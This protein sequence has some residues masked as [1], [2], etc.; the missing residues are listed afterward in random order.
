MIY[1][2]FDP[3]EVCCILWQ[4]WGV[5]QNI[6]SFIVDWSLP[7]LRFNRV[8]VSNSRKFGKFDLKFDCTMSNGSEISYFSLLS[9]NSKSKLNHRLTKID[10][11][12]CIINV[13]V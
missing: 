5:A 11:R 4:V 3:L 6:S 12:K 10:K 8:E 7:F 13:V 2:S 9:V 1:K